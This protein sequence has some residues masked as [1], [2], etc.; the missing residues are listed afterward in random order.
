MRLIAA[1]IGSTTRLISMKDAAIDEVIDEIVR[2]VSRKGSGGARVKAIPKRD[3]VTWSIHVKEAK[4][5][6]KTSCC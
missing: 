3:R 6:L 4:Y 1:M 2:L 5:K